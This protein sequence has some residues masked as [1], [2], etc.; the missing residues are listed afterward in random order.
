MSTK[1]VTRL[2]NFNNIEQGNYLYENPQRVEG[3]NYYESNC[4][5]NLEEDDEGNQCITPVFFETKPLITPTGIYNIG[6]DYMLDLEIPRGSKLLDFLMEEDDLNIN[7]VMENSEEWF[8]KEFPLS[9]V[10]EKYKSCIL[11]KNQGSNPVLRVNINSSNNMPKIEIF[12]EAG[13]SMDISDVESNCRVACIMR[14][15]GL[16]FYRETFKP[17][18]T[19]YKIKLFS[20]SSTESDNLLPPGD[21]FSDAESSSDN[22]TDD[23][24]P[25]T[26]NDVNDNDSDNESVDIEKE[27]FNINNLENEVSDDSEEDSEE[28]SNNDSD[29][30]DNNSN[31][32]DEHDNDENDDTENNN[33]VNDDL[34]LELNLEEVNITSGDGGEDEELEEDSVNNNTTSSSSITAQ[35]LPDFDF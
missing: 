13:E 32:E 16:S 10:Q 24:M 26:F 8:G 34:D 30:S 6:N 31:D 1:I 18:Y 21:I 28:D 35:E 15:K 2:I 33:N 11:F 17:T 29:D 14:K 22:D 27:L 4:F 3:G 19:V 20:N 12:N 5:Y 9:A 7:T 25:E 23:D